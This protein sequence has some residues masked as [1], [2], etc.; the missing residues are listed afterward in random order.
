LHSFIDR[1]NDRSGESAGDPSAQRNDAGWPVLLRVFNT[2]TMH[3]DELPSPDGKQIRIFVCGP[4]VYDYAHLGHARTYLALDMMVRYLRFKGYRPYVLMNIT[5]IDERIVKKSK[6][7]GRGAREISNTFEKSFLEDIKALGIETVDRFERAADHIPDMIG[8]IEQLISTG[9]A[10]ETETGVYFDISRLASYG[11][12]SHQS[13]MD[14]KL[15]RLELCSTKHHPEDFSLWRKFEEIPLWDSPWGPGRP[16]WHIEDTAI[17]MKYLGSAYDIHV[18]GAELVFPHHEAEMAQGE[19]LSGKRPFVKYWIHTGMLNVGGVK[20]SKSLGNVVTIR[21]ALATYTAEQL[22]FFFANTHY[23]RVANFC[24]AELLRARRE[25]EF[26]QQT[27]RKLGACSSGKAAG[28][29]DLR[30]LRDLSLAETRFTSAMDR[31]F[32]TARAI[33]V[34]STFLRGVRSQMRTHIEFD[35]DTCQTVEKRVLAL[36][37]VIGMLAV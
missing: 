8:Q 23:R 35:A 28:K 14:L 10:Y 13:T 34:L 15:R 32:D 12:L 31:D 25:L 4:T 3:D 27:I 7:T 33:R 22:R 29:S 16:G 36:A 30:L 24:K 18:G 6:E 37:N 17:A 20:M 9:Y 1:E 5:D 21:E 19:A 26:M 11:Q 2:L